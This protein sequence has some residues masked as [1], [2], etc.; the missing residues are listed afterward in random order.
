MDCDP[1]MLDRLRDTNHPAGGCIMSA[2]P[3]SG[4]VDTSLRVFG[5]ENVYVVGASTFPTSS[6]SNVTFTA[7]ALACRLADHLSEAK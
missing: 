4:V 2:D 3:G 7:M 1:R 6:D 5:T